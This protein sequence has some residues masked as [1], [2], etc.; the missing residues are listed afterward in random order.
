MVN[1]L[2]NQHVNNVFFFFIYIQKPSLQKQLIKILKSNNADFVDNET[3]Y[4]LLKLGT[5]YL[6][7]YNNKTYSMCSNN[8]L[9]LITEQIT[10]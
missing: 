8:L 1:I 2:K 4:F 7:L 10:E 9:K 6:L 5:K 3:P